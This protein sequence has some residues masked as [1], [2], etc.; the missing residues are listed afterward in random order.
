MLRYEIMQD[1]EDYKAGKLE[2]V[3][4]EQVKAEAYAMED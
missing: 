2:T 1:V 4:F 3:P